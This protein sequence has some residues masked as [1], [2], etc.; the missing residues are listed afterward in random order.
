TY[1][2]VKNVTQQQDKDNGQVIVKAL[3]D[4]ES[5]V[6]MG[7]GMTNG[8][9]K[10]TL[11]IYVRDGRYKYEITDFVHEPDAGNSFYD[12]NSSLLT[13]SE[14]YPF[15]TKKMET[16]WKNNVWKDLKEQTENKMNVLIEVLEN[17]MKTPIETENDDW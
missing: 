6:W 14:T 11:F 10:Y 16:K 3:F 9:V 8:I 5:K 12:G 7:H 13:V 15:E 1:N 4:Y 17:K 2:D